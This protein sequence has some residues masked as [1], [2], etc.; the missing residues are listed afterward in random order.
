[1]L[2]FKFKKLFAKNKV[3]IQQNEVYYKPYLSAMLLSIFFKEEVTTTL[4]FLWKKA[5]LC[6]KYQ[7]DLTIEQ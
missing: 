1:M 2:V 4:P 5:R 7:T 6:Y 3:E